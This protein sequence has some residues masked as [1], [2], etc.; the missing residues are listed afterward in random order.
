MDTMMLRKSDG[1]DVEVELV[2]TFKLKEFDHN[3]VFYKVDNEVYAARYI[4]EGDTTKLDTKLSKEEKSVLND[5]FA[6]LKKGGKL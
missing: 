5:F 4:E 3:Y 2:L 1:T 6:S